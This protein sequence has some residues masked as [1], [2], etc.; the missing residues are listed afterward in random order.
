[1]EQRKNPAPP[2]TLGWRA[3]ERADT[4]QKEAFRFSG[5]KD[6]IPAPVIDILKGAERPKKEKYAMPSVLDLMKDDQQ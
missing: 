4:R 6:S 1:M 3:A 2:P 5:A